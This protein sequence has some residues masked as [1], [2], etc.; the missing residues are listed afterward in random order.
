M[1]PE[2]QLG[3]NVALIELGLDSLMAV[4]VPQVVLE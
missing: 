2:E 3:D 1:L 4:D